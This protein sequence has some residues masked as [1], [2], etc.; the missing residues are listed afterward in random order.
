MGKENGNASSTLQQ[1]ESYKLKEYKCSLYYSFNFSTGQTK[2]WKK[3]THK[4]ILFFYLSEFK[5]YTI[6]VLVR[7]WIY[8]HCHIQLRSIHGQSLFGGLSFVLQKYILTNPAVLPLVSDQTDVLAYASND[9]YRRLLSVS[10]LAKFTTP[11]I[12]ISSAFSK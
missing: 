2:F 7:L 6:T 3:N 12:S 4:E 1:Q 8:S 5:L 9:A 11:Y 10:A